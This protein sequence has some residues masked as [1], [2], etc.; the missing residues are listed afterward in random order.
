MRRKPIE[1]TH[2]CEM[3]SVTPGANRTFCITFSDPNNMGCEPTVSRL[4]RL[5]GK[6][7]LLSMK[8]RGE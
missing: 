7:V 1:I 6:K 5:E 8:E 3:Q 2:E 4:S